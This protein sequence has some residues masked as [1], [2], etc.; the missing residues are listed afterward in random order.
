MPVQVQHEQL[1][2]C[3]MQL[4]ITVPPED[5]KK[6][7]ET[8]FGRYTRRVQ[9]PGF[10]PGKAPRH[11]ME[12]VVNM[13]EIYSAAY[14]S[15]VANAYEQAIRETGISPY[16]G[17]QPQ[18]DMPDDELTMDQP[19]TFK[20]TVALNPTVQMGSLEGITV[21][22]VRVTIRDA[23]VE[24]E[25]ERMRVADSRFVVSDIAAEPGDRIR[26]VVHFAEDSEG[27]AGEGEEGVVI[28]C[29]HHG[30]PG[31]THSHS[32]TEEEGDEA[33]LL[34]LGQNLPEFDANLT[35]LTAGADTTFPFTYPDDFE[36]EAL[37]GI[38]TNVS[39]RVLEVQRRETPELTDEWAGANGCEDLA[40]LRVRIREQLQAT[41]DQDSEERMRDDLIRE[42]VARSEIHFPAEMVDDEVADRTHR[43]IQALGEIGTSLQEYLASRNIS[44]RSFHAAMRR[45][46][47]DILRNSLL[48]IKMGEE[49]G[50][51]VSEEDVEQYIEER[52]VEENV[53]S[54]Q[55]RRV[56]RDTGGLNDIQNRLFYLKASDYLAGLASIEEVAG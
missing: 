31:H 44:L 6:A 16:R 4:T 48:L 45:D 43:M 47:E 29:P 5:L 1:E 46:A 26:A 34:Q 23:D 10:R 15:A 37:R 54:S 40:A 55:Y 52:A 22:R 35:G 13:E 50:I 8:T 53:Q 7:S 25:L 19:L 39:V 18:V 17:S 3:R 20:A 32:P 14:E 9:V 24:T 28:D 38:T 49:V 42:V 30:E 27:E 2:P 33:I 12:R 21:R 11:L 51:R 56:L 36:E 41:A